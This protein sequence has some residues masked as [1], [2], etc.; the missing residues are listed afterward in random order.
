[1][2]PPP[3]KSSTRPVI[4]CTENKRE[5]HALVDDSGLVFPS[6]RGKPLGDKTRW[7]L[8]KALGIPA[9]PHGFR[10]SFR[11]WA[12][13]HTR[14]SRAVM[15]AA[16]AHTNPG[17]TEAAYARSDLF[18]R[19]RTLMDQWAAYLGQASDRRLLSCLP[20]SVSV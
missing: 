13:E 11:D 5:A 20:G 17:K 12:Q 4:S 3:P 2:V 8:L 18:V 16:L 6:S 15:E 19:R 14:A 10:S 9:V 7:Q 1:M